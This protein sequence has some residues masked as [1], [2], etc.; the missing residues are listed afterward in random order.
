VILIVD[1]RR[2]EEGAPIIA[3]SEGNPLPIDKIP[4]TQSLGTRQSVYTT[5][6]E[7]DAYGESAAVRPR[8]KSKR[9]SENECPPNEKEM[10]S[11]EEQG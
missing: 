6:V 8:L 9:L 5:E 10:A 2:E 7:T 3:R 11:F 4:P 1:C